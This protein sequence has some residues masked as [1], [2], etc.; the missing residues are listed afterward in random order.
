MTDYR[1]YKYSSRRQ[2]YINIA[3]QLY[4]APALSTV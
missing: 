1:S 4:L 2:P 3:V